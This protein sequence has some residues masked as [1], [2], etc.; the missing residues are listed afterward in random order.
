MKVVKILFLLVFISGIAFGQIKIPQYYE[1]ARISH[2]LNGKLFEG[3]RMKIEKA[4]AAFTERNLAQNEEEA[5]QMILMMIG[6][7]RNLNE[8]D[9]KKIENFLSSRIKCE[10]FKKMW[11]D[12]KISESDKK[13]WFEKNF[14]YPYEKTTIN[15][16]MDLCILRQ[17][18]MYAEKYVMDPDFFRLVPGTSEK[19]ELS[20]DIVSEDLLVRDDV[21]VTRALGAGWSATM[22]I[23]EDSGQQYFWILQKE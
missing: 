9:G 4:I 21:G 14:P 12:S 15:V 11:Y 7:V 23:V 22:V 20:F 16:I 17:G 13:K 10:E 6:L 2:E 19:R 8:A 5:K 1:A 3:H 18:C